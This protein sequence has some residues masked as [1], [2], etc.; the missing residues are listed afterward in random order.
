MELI[1]EIK[2]TY[3]QILKKIFIFKVQNVL[4]VET[5]ARMHRMRAAKFDD[6]G[7]GVVKIFLISSIVPVW[8][9][10]KGTTYI[11]P[12]YSGT[13][14][15]QQDRIW[16]GRAPVFCKTLRGKISSLLGLGQPLKLPDIHC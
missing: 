15:L 10:T 16:Q 7:N 14:L 4:K 11:T 2:G 3:F 6:F 13:I 12:P 1:L 9:I 8:K 5:L